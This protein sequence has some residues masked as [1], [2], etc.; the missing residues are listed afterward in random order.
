MPRT[1]RTEAYAAEGVLLPE[2]SGHLV[3]GVHHYSCWPMWMG[4]RLKSETP[5][6]E[7]VPRWG[8]RLGCPK[9]NPLQG[10]SVN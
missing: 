8:S 5:T 6:P 3:L 7:K 1:N 10:E 9:N 4:E 2:W